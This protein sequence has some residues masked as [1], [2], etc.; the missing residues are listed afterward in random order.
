MAWLLLVRLAMIR[1]PKLSIEPSTYIRRS[2]G[3]SLRVKCFDP[4]ETNSTTITWFRWVTLTFTFKPK[5]DLETFNE[6]RLRRFLS[7]CGGYRKAETLWSAF[8]VEMFTAW[9]WRWP[10]WSSSRK[11]ATL[12]RLPNQHSN[13]ILDFA[14]LS[15]SDSGQYLCRGQNRR[16]FTEEVVT[17]ELIGMPRYLSLSCQWKKY[18]K[19]SLSTS[20]TT[21]YRDSTQ[22]GEWLSDGT[23]AFN[24]TDRVS[25]PRPNSVGGYHL[26]SIGYCRS[27]EH[28]S[29]L[30][31]PME[32]F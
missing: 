8:I 2:K 25:Q 5:R 6:C 26:A 32:F 23:A 13:G 14:S 17:L 3:E 16:G 20:I 7:R 12:I 27:I 11:D 29:S 1:R 9:N 19:T 21:I 15:F 31:Y 22:D 30:I 18:S 24:S 10:M 4:Y 28:Q